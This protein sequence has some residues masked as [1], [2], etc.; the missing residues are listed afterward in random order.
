MKTTLL[1]VLV[2]TFAAAAARADG[3]AANAPTAGQPA[4]S[5]DQKATSDAKRDQENAA[6]AQPASLKAALVDAEAKAKKQSATVKVEVKGL[7]LVDPG[8]AGE[9]AKGGQ[10]HLHY[11]LDDGPVIATTAT[12]LSFHGLKSGAH[13]ISVMLAGNDH[14]P[15]GP[16]ET[17]SVTVP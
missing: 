3:I 17:L 16:S 11:K 2:L 15:L 5:Q 12:K 6:S 13:A 10:G 14:S 7:K 4:S 9:K 1:A 8:E